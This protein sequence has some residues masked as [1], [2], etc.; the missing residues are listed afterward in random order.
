MS[1]KQLWAPWRMDYLRSAGPEE[2]IFC[3]EDKPDEDRERLI[4]VRGGTSFVVMNHYPYTNGH[5]MVAP[6]RHLADPAGLSQAETLEMHRLTV[7][8]QA[9][10]RD[11]FAAEGFNL[12]M[13]VGAAAGAGIADHIHQHIVPRWGGDNNFMPV[14]ADVRVIPEHLETTYLRL[15]EMFA[16]FSL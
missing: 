9:V 5:L 4:L 6:Y 13:N 1:M 7:A 11:A 12:G 16:R 10:L 8:C 15:S 14:F 3:V 2:C